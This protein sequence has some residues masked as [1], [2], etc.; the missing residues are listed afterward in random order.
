MGAS[1]SYNIFT[2]AGELLG[3]LLL[4]TR[5]TTLLGALVCFGVM[6][7]VAMLNFSYDVPVKLFSMHLLAMSLFLMAPDLGRLARMFVLNRPV[8]PAVFRPLSRRTWVNRGAILLRTLVVAAFLGMTLYGAHESRKTF[9]DLMPRSPLYGIWNVEEFEVDGQVRPPL[10]TDAQRWRR[11]VFDYPKMIA[12]QLMSDSRQRYGLDL[13]P[14]A[15][16]MALTKRDDPAWKAAF[17]YTAAGAGA[18][19]AGGHAGRPEDQG[20]APP[21][22]H[23]RFPADQPGI[24]LDQRVSLQPLSRGLLRTSRSS[25]TDSVAETP[26]APDRRCR[27][28]RRRN[29]S[30]QSRYCKDRRCLRMPGGHDVGR[31]T[32]LDHAM[33]R[34]PQGGPARRRRGDLAALLRPGARGGAAPPAAGARTRRSRT[35]R[36]WP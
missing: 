14:D 19:R 9:G 27:L 30:L 25:P 12:I 11:V 8:E 33:A 2:G 16:T 15:R 29:A 22:G 35:A 28:D 21:G 1:E 7:H 32:R 31:G 24:P 17:S 13:D 5:R 18:A 23:L 26:S 4:T 6:S 36:T 34:G 10:I 20:P 3:G